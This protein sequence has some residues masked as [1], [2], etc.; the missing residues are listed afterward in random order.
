MEKPNIKIR[1][2]PLTLE[3]TDADTIERTLP[4]I[5]GCVAAI[6]A[7][8]NANTSEAQKIRKI[9]AAVRACFDGIFGAGTGT[10]VCGDK[11]RWDICTNAFVDLCEAAEKVQQATTQKIEKR[12]EA[13]NKK[14]AEKQNEHTDAAP[15]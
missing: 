14:V 12:T 7:A 3:L 10:K 5:E 1:G 15:A 9:C 2:V 11:D 4:A 6:K 13:L 8:S